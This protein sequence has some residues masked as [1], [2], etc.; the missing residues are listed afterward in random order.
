MEMTVIILKQICI[1]F[2]YMA[3]GCLLFKKQLITKEGSKSLAHLL[4]YVILPC[5]IV[6]AFCIE[7]TAENMKKI[8][9]SF[10]GGVAILGVAIILA[11][12]PLRKRPIDNFGASFSNAGFMAI[13]LISAVLGDGSVIYVAAVTALLN[14]LQWTYGQMILSGDKKN[15]SLKSVL[16][17]PLVIALGIGIVIFLLQIKLPSLVT[18]CIN[19]IAQLNSPIAM[20]ILG[21]YLGEVK[22]KEIL[23]DKNAWRCVLVRL[24][25]IPAVTLV[26]LRLL[27]GGELEAAQALL[28]AAIAPVGSNVAVYA[29]KLNKDY[30]YAVKIVCLSTLLSII[31]IPVTMMIFLKLW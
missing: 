22:I 30:G 13:P 7:R 23:N 5:V 28:I 12:L 29:Q 20:M 27:F 14:A 8:G 2:L 11:G 21:V 10:G 4:L 1:M 26:V 25:I 16:T 17:S 19:S 15:I 3:I 31:T 9:I 24:V 18:S 6:K